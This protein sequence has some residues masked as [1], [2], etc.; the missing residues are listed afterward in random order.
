MMP[1]HHSSAMRNQ[2]KR[3]SRVDMGRR[4]EPEQQEK[5]PS[6]DGSGKSASLGH[7]IPSGA[8]SP[9]NIDSDELWREGWH[10]FPRGNTGELQT[11]SFKPSEVIYSS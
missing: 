8:K 3:L 9:S 7:N 1:V 11:L 5:N 10:D 6:C 4:K 2:S